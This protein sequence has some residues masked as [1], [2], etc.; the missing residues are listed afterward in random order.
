MNGVKL[1]RVVAVNVAVSEAK[2]DG[3]GAGN[4]GCHDDSS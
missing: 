3:I 2:S 4:G 1:M